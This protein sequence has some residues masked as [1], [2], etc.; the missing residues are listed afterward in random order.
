MNG[1][2]EHSVGWRDMS[3]AARVTGDNSIFDLHPIPN[4]RCR[5]TH[6]QPESMAARAASGDG[7][8]DRCGGAAAAAPPPRRPWGR[9]GLGSP[10]RWTAP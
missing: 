8:A 10:R 1:K 7:P 6:L 2:Q 9:S 4:T 3:L 5:T